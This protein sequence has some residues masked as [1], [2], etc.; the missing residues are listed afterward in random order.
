MLILK[1][2]LQYLSAFLQYF[3]SKVST[4]TEES[5]STDGGSDGHASGVD[6]EFFKGGE[7]ANMGRGRCK[8]ECVPPPAR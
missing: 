4:S 3:A 8:R 7:G 1:P 5:I 6:P 2:K